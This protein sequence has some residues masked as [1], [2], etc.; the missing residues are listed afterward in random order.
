M[1]KDLVSKVLAITFMAA[2][3]GYF[4]CSD[5]ITQ[6]ERFKSLPVDTVLQEVTTPL[7]EGY[8]QYILAFISLGVTIIILTELVGFFVKLIFFRKVD[9]E[10]TV[11]NHNITIQ[12]A[13]AEYVKEKVSEETSRV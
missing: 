9:E 4:V 11:H 13:G 2:I 12:M 7:F 10:K 6:I 3:F 5:E 8:A 1:K